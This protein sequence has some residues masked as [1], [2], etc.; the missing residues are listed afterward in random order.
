MTIAGE[1]NMKMLARSVAL[2]VLCTLVMVGNAAADPNE[3]QIEKLEARRYAVLIAGDWDAFE[4]LLADEFFYNQAGGKTVTKAAY[5]QTLRSG[6]TKVHRAEREKP[7]MRRYGDVMVVTGVAHVDVTL[8]GEDKTLHSR[9]LHVWVR[10]GNDWK[11][12]ARQATFLP[13]SN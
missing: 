4:S 3:D 13:S 12:A 5:L 2:L 6:S 11:L 10:Q 9:F 7:L 1:T 8:N